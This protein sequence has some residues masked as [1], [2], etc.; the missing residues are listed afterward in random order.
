[1]SGAPSVPVPQRKRSTRDLA[2]AVTLRPRDIFELYGIPTSTLC[3]I[4]TQE[5]ATRRPPSRLIKGRG[6]RK[7][8]RLFPRAEFEAWFA[9]WTSEGDFSPNPKPRKAA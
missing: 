4:A 8:I 3:R 9:R 1:M 6:G 7:G 2:H 5:D